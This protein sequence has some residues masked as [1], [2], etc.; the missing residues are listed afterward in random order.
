MSSEPKPELTELP[1]V[2]DADTWR[3]MTEA[4][5]H[6]FLVVCMEYFEEEA[7]L[8]AEGLMAE[9][10]PHSSAKSRVL[11]VLR[12]HFQRTNR[13]IYVAPELMV[14]Y[15]REKPIN[16]D[17][18]AVLGVPDPGEDDRRLCWSVVD[19]GRGV[20]LIIEVLHRGD[21]RKDLVRNVARYARLGIR[22]Y[23]VYDR[24]TERIVG[25]RLSEGQ[26]AYQ[27]LH[28]V[29]GRL[30]S[31]VLELD[32]AVVDAKLRF[33]HGTGELADSDSLIAA[34]SQMVDDNVHAFETEQ[35][36]RERAEQERDSAVQERDSAV[37]E[38]DSAVQERDSAVQERD[39]AVQERQA[40]LDVLREA[41]R[42][43]LRGRGLTPN[44]AEEA[45][46]LAASA[47]Q[48]DRWLP[49]CLAADSVAAALDET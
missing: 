37:Q 46:L 2:P 48:L 20:D 43:I 31:R 12:R 33:F 3:A 19:E 49:R 28:P 16:P 32:L 40:A 17:I 1:D 11:D 24:R 22:E 9:G 42:T 10:R 34:L 14:L 26:T 5:K 8:M 44:A 4:Q 30:Q 7:M 45:R 15:P 29:G 13:Q 41:V 6:A 18:I 36:A 38:R 27:S 23:F 25:W 47:A 35:A 39:S 21:A